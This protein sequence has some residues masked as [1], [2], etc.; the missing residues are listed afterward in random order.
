VRELKLVPG[1]LYTSDVLKVTALVV[2]VGDAVE[3]H[4]RSHLTTMRHGNECSTLER[5]GASRMLMWSG[6]MLHDSW[7]RIA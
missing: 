4:T 2:F 1:G 6:T 5:T 3:I 7:R